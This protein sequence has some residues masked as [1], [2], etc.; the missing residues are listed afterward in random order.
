MDE[1]NVV[2][3]EEFE[4]RRLVKYGPVSEEEPEKK[5]GAAEIIFGSIFFI[6]LD[7]L[8][9]VEAGI[10][11]TDVVSWLTQ[12]YFQMKGV[13]GSRMVIGNLIELIPGVD[14]LPVRTI[15]Y[16]LTVRNANH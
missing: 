15:T 7:I 5:F 14:Y 11:G 16:W 8:D 9:W 10:P 4:E 1:D 2:S 12:F 6:L 13:S 3:N